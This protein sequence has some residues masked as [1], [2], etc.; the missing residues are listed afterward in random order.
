MSHEEIAKD[1]LV[2]LITKINI[3]TKIGEDKYA[4]QWAADAYRIIY[5]AVVSVDLDV[6]QDV[7][8]DVVKEKES[9]AKPG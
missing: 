3:P 9:E 6:V 1:I 5:K 7:A 8:G 2:A 4:A